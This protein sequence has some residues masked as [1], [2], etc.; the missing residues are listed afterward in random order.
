MPRRP[1]DEHSSGTF[2]RLVEKLGH[3]SRECIPLHFDAAINR[4]S[5]CDGSEVVPELCTLQEVL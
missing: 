3:P 5:A 4:M 2:L 1:N